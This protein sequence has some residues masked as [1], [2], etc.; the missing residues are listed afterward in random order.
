[1]PPE[2]VD[3]Q[4]SA[5]TAVSRLLW[6]EQTRGRSSTS[7]RGRASVVTRHRHAR[8]SEEVG[9]LRHVERVGAWPREAGGARTVEGGY[10]GSSRAPECTFV[11]LCWRRIY[12]RTGAV[13]GVARAHRWRPHRRRPP[14]AGRGASPAAGRPYRR[15]ERV[16]LS[17]AARGASACG[18]TRAEESRQGWAAE[19]GPAGVDCSSAGE[20]CANRRPF[21]SSAFHP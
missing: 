6:E 19:A 10:W 11:C 2:A 1:M 17:A 16:E 21:S 8:R 12:V 5:C 3:R 20:G 7:E 13:D 9:V 15:G 18:A 4:R 14:S